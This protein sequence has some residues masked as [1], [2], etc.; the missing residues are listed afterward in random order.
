MS[1]E[2][3]KRKNYGVELEQN[4]VAIAIADLVAGGEVVEGLA[5]GAADGSVAVETGHKGI[6]D[7]FLN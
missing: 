6:W 1:S 2:C 3:Q 5:E 7:G 4:V